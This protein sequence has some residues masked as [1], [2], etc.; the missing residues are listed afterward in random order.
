MNH[1]PASTKRNIQVI[2]TSKRRFDVIFTR[3][4]RCMVAGKGHG[5]KYPRP[6]TPDIPNCSLHKY[7]L[8]RTFI[9]LLYSNL[10]DHSPDASGMMARFFGT[11]KAEM[12][13]R[14]KTC[15]ETVTSQ[16]GHNRTWPH[17]KNGNGPRVNSADTWIHVVNS[18]DVS[19]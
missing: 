6:L 19:F 16:N 3:S 18:Y 17:P 12:A 8:Q 5:N 4:L 14:Q 11:I 1:K 2:I 7:T 10:C 15:L 13:T 9:I